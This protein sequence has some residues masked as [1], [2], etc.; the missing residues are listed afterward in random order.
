MHTLIGMLYD[1][2]HVLTQ[3]GEHQTSN[4]LEIYSKELL[5]NVDQYLCPVMVIAAL[6]IL[7]Y[8]VNC[9]N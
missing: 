7:L 6:F 5:R 4:I 8:M 2:Y 9:N 3:L 1:I